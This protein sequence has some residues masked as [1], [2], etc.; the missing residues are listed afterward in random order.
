MSELQAL[1]AVAKSVYTFCKKCDAD[2]YHTVLAHTSET[3]AKVQCEICKSKKTFKLE[4]PK[5]A[6][7][8]GSK[9]APSLRSMAAKKNLHTDE[10]ST[11]LDKRASEQA[12]AYSMKI[13]FDVN[14]K[15]NHATFGVGFVKSVFP[16]KIEVMFQEELKSLVHNRP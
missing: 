11:L 13:K 5:K 1:P 16:D 14:H 2:K 7:T 15:I 3:S 10:Y 4:S 12:V 6:K 8:A 9:K